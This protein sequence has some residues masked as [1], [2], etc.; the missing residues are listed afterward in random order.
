VREHIAK[1]KE[2]ITGF[3]GTRE[4]EVCMAT[5]SQSRTRLRPA[6]MVNRHLNRRVIYLAPPRKFR[7]DMNGARWRPTP[8]VSQCNRRRSSACTPVPLQCLNHNCL[9]IV[10]FGECTGDANGLHS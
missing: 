3:S 4:E 6:L 1:G 2:Q 10:V 7:I 9:G 8:P 5:T